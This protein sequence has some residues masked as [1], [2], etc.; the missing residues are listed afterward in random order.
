[1]SDC[2]ECRQVLMPNQE[3]ST[4]HIDHTLPLIR[5]IILQEVGGEGCV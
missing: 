1:M 4:Y 2:D 3:V 5:R